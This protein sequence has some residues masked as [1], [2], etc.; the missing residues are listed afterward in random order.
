VIAGSSPDWE[1]AFG[2]EDT[3]R[4]IFAQNAERWHAAA[5]QP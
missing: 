3:L 2:I 1:P 5:R 4:E